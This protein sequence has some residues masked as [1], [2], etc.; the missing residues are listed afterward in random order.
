MTIALCIQ[1]LASIISY[2]NLPLVNF[3]KISLLAPVASV[4]F[5]F[6]GVSPALANEKF[7]AG[8]LES[9]I[10]EI[11]QYSEDQITSAYTFCHPLFSI[12]S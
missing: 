12:K 11:D 5:L 10:P 9:A 6:A 8:N 4:A 1:L 7:N 2:L 3:F